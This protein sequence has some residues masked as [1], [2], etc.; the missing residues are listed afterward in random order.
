[1]IRLPDQTTDLRVLGPA[2]PTADVLRAVARAALADDSAEVIDVHAGATGYDYTSIATGGLYRVIGTARTAIGERPWS[3]F[4]KVLQHPRHWPLIDQVPPAAAA[5]IA[6][7]FPWRDELDARE[8]VLPA[9]PT[10]LRV[11]DE[12][13][14]VDLGDDRVAWWME[15]IDVDDDPWPDEAYAWAAHL[16][17]RLAARRTA[18]LPAGAS[19]LPAGFAVRKVVDSR[20]PVLSAVLDDDALWGRPV[21]AD[22]VDGDFRDDLRRAVALLPGLLDEMATLPTSL[23][24]GDAAP[25]NLLRPRGSASAPQRSGGVSCA[26]LWGREHC[27][28]RSRWNAS[29]HRR[30]TSTWRSCGAGPVSRGGCST[31]SSGTSPS[32]RRERGSGRGQP[33][34]RPGRRP[35]RCAP[36]ACAA[37][38]P[39]CRRGR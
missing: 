16:L 35:G 7:L 38:P 28:G 30:P 8:Q 13:A 2:E 22:V 29:T 23:P 26:A 39:S 12:Y 25:V 19:E 11:P 37:R 32:P 17:A 5:E 31:W 9:L 27:S 1:M 20:G 34:W 6:E 14:A 15:D 4:L 33:R 21:V 24:H 36:R 18:G 10:G 3:S